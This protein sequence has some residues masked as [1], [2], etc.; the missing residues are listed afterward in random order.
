MIEIKK[1]GINDR[2]SPNGTPQIRLTEEK[3]N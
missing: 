1:K 3:G 2:V